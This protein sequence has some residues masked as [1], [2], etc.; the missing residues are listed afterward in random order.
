VNDNF[1]QGRSTVHTKTPLR[2]SYL[3]GGS[4]Y[5]DFFEEHHGSVL[6]CTFDWFVRVDVM[7]LPPVS[8]E[9]F[10]IT[11]RQTES[12]NELDDIEHPTVR[13]SLRI[14][15]WKESLNIA[16]MSSVQGGTGL[17]SSSSFAVGLLKALHYIAGVAIDEEALT[18]LAIKIE[19]E[20]LGEEGGWQDQC[21]AAWGG[22]SEYRFEKNRIKNQVVIPEQK[23]L[24]LISDC[25]LLVWI[26]NESHSSLS[27]KRT[28]EGLRR[29]LSIKFLSRNAELSR[30]T[31]NQLISCSEITVDKFLGI[32][33]PAIKENWEMKK[34]F[35]SIE[36][37]ENTK[38][39]IEQ[40]KMYG[41]DS[42]KILGGGDRGFLFFMGD[43]DKISKAVKSGKLGFTFRPRL[44][45]SGSILS[46]SI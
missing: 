45:S 35:S 20:I 5:K 8:R 43:P 30:V 6:G 4:D 34:I 23:D 12:V 22:F 42:F 38:F 29:D 7:K 15:K 13:E 2:I 41:L 3:G 14:L 1:F 27:A 21:H 28:Q 31:A 24:D 11:Y 17:G 32:M 9:N 44:T 36:I 37:T 39:L 18:K 26:G 33:E 46:E 16:T 40:A 25:H 19:R 10:R